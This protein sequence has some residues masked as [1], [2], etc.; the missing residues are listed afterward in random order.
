MKIPIP[1]VCDLLR[2]I[3]SS[4]MYPT[5]PWRSLALHKVHDITNTLGWGGGDSNQ[6]HSFSVDIGTGL[7]AAFS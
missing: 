2:E 1:K 7:I 4:N 3:F 6:T 5:K